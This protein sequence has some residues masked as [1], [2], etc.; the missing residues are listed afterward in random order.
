[1]SLTSRIRGSSPQDRELQHVLR[2]TLPDRSLF[3]TASGNDPLTPKRYQVMA[4]P[5]SPGRAHSGLVGTAFDYLARAVVARV[6]DRN[7]GGLIAWLVAEQGLR[8][9]RDSG[10]LDRRTMK[11]ADHTYTSAVDS[12]RAYAHRAGGASIDDVITPCCK[13]AR[14]E[15]LARGGTTA[16]LMSLPDLLDGLLSSEPTE[17]IQD[18]ARLIGVF[19]NIFVNSGAVSSESEVVFNPKFAAFAIGGADA[20]VFIDGTLYDFKTSKEPG[21]KW[22]D[23]AQLWGYYLLS[24][25]FGTYDGGEFTL[26]ADSLLFDRS[27]RRLALY[28]A[29][30]GEIE[31]MEVGAVSSA[32]RLRAIEDFRDY[33]QRL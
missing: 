9:L 31:Y 26:D 12:L 33:M 13:L 21:Y 32:H 27:I 16:Q 5:L 24:E 17:V 6:A 23:I 8:V 25:T 2:S 22:Q 20:D 15:R 28:K 30:F 18:L 11:R 1:V 10:L 29:R 7:K 14:L 3:R 4:A 19:S